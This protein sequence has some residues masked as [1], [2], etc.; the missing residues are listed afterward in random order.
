MGFTAGIQFPAGAT[1]GCF[2]FATVSRPALGPT[3]P[4]IQWVLGALSLGVKRQEREA[5]HS[6]PRTSEV[7][8]AWSYTSSPP[9][10]L[11]GVVL[12]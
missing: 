9:I 12:S 4:H 5:D 3:Q 7:K 8:N 2:P 10:H 11:N 6:P 1:I